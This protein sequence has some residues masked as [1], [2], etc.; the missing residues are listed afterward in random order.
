MVA[1]QLWPWWSCQVLP[2]GALIFFIGTGLLSKFNF[3]VQVPNRAKAESLQRKAM[4]QRCRMQSCLPRL[5]GWLWAGPRSWTQNEPPWIFLAGSQP[6]R[7][8]HTQH[9]SPGTSAWRG[10]CQTGAWSLVSTRRR[11]SE[12]TRDQKKD[13]RDQKSFRQK[14]W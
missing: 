7:R 2:K 6:P 9:S 4:R 11:A 14:Y 1:Q 12:D 3:C 13:T 10:H 5:L 8:P